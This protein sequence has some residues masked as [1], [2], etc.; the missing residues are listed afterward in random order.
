MIRRKEPQEL[1]RAI[2]NTTWSITVAL[3]VPSA[4]LT[5]CKAKEETPHD[6]GQR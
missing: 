1:M 2:R 5:G 3:L 4:L 6:G